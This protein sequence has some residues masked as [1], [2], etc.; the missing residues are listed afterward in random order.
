MRP[1][2]SNEKKLETSCL[3]NTT[4]NMC[5]NDFKILK[6]SIEVWKLWDLSIS[7]DIICEG[8]GKIL[9]GFCNFATSNE[10]IYEEQSESWQGCG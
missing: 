1:Y 6:K 9:S 3:G 10:N 2:L 8:C 4:T 7:H 5:S